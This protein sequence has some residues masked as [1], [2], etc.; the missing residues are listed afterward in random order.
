MAIATCGFSPLAMICVMV[1][2]GCII[3]FA[4][5][6][7]SRKFPPEMPIVGSCSM[8]ISA[9]CHSAPGEGIIASTE[10]L[11]WGVVPGMLSAEGAGHCCFSRH[12]VE[13]P[14][15]GHMYAGV[16][17]QKTGDLDRWK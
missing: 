12:K 6:L 8:A 11:Q 9:A 3:A 16:I 17:G 15:P 13:L 1:V 7:G 10:A 5:T 2:G 4:L 14:E